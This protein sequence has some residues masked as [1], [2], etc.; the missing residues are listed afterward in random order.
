MFLVSEKL[1]ITCN[2]GVWFS[3]CTSFITTGGKQLI[4]NT[5][6]CGRQGK[7]LSM[8]NAIEFVASQKIVPSHPAGFCQASPVECEG[9]SLSVDNLDTHVIG[10]FG[11]ACHWTVDK[12]V[13]GFAKVLFTAARATESETVLRFAQSPDEIAQCALHFSSSQNVDKYFC[14]RSTNHSTLTF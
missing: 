7:R 10:H 6:G 4:F 13:N 5:S 2:V 12:H 9:R 3:N 14:Q 11:H 1:W 8:V